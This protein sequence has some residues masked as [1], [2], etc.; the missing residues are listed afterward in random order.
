MNTKYIRKSCT[1]GCCPASSTDTGNALVF[2]SDDN[3]LMDQSITYCPPRKNSVGINRPVYANPAALQEY[4]TFNCYFYPRLN[5]KY[6]G[7]DNN[8]GRLYAESIPLGYIPDVKNTYGYLRGSYGIVNEVGLAFGECTNGTLFQIGPTDNDDGS[9]VVKRL[10]YSDELSN[11]A[12]ER[13]DNCRDA[14]TL[15]GNLIEEYGY[16]GTGE[17]LPMADRKTGEAWVFEMAPA[18]PNSDGEQLGGYWVATRVPDGEVFFAANEFRTRTINRNNLGFDNNQVAGLQIFA[19]FNTDEL[20]FLA[21]VSKGEYNHPYYSLRRVWRAFDL[22]APSLNLPSNV[23]NGLTYEYPFTI[24]PDEKITLEKIQSIYRDHY[25]GTEFDLSKGL[26]AGP[27]KYP[28]RAN[29]MKYDLSGDIGIGNIDGAWER[30]ICH[31]YTGYAFINELNPA[32][33]NPYIGQYCWLSLG[34]PCSSQYI[35]LLVDDVNERFTKT[36]PNIYDEDKAWWIFNRVQ[37]S[38][39]HMYSHKIK[40]VNELQQIIDKR[41]KRMIRKVSNFI[42]NDN[43]YR[44]F[45]NEQY[46]CLDDWKELYIKI[47]VMY[48]QTFKLQYNSVESIGY[49]NADETASDWLDYMTTEWR[50]GP[51]HY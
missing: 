18:K 13:C 29:T 46:R 42:I 19:D 41:F 39:S 45:D 31:Y 26:T 25:E 36:L 30:P 48:N 35:P 24:K 17:C 47:S 6:F 20:D 28:H 44:E 37:E 40:L 12:L 51:I 23:I 32:Q 7:K 5:T 4:P 34:T 14:I 21:T 33:I 27:W 50:N 9:G 2:H 15:M 43:I 11:I 3:E 49:I 38:V 22:L 1:T 10:F 16:W 8:Y